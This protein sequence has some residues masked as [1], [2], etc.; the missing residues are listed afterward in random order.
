[1]ASI[2]QNIIKQARKK[3]KE[4][5]YE[6]DP[7]KD[8]NGWVPSGIPA[9]NLLLLTPGYPVGMVI[10]ICGQKQS[11]KTTAAWHFISA[12]QKAVEEALAI[13]IRTERRGF[14]G[15]PSQIG[16]SEK[17]VLIEK[18]KNIE[19]VFS[20]MEY[21]LYEYGEKN[22]NLVMAFVW[23]S[24][25]GTAA[26]AELEGEA[27]DE[28]MAVAARTIKKNLRRVTQLLDDKRAVFFVVNQVYKKFGAYKYGKQTTA[29]GGEGVKFHS[30]VRLELTEVSTIKTGEKLPIGQM[31]K[32]EILKCDFS[33]P[34]RS[35]EIPL[36]YGVGFV[37]NKD[38]LK[39][40]LELGLLEK[41][42]FGYRATFGSNEK[43][44]NEKEYYELMLEDAKFRQF[45]IVLL[46][47]RYKEFIYKKRGVEV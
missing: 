20:T 33:S 3:G 7:F 26:K 9:L 24:L 5:L 31:S 29:Y 1:M 35:V 12:F 43:W 15:Y 10:E 44:A 19:G 28:F 16:V 42:K 30:S 8:I 14:K 25:G 47:L 38:D 13:Y 6:L 39:N 46:E 37:P 17:N 22:D 23:D 27:S 34:K 32:F 4:T 45:F 11:G 36:L 18:P 41:Y 40:A 21:Y 2:V